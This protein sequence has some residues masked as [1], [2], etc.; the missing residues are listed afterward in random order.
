MKEL[1]TYINEG[2]LGNVDDIMDKT[3]VAVYKDVISNFIM[4]RFSLNSYGNRITSK[5]FE[6]EYDNVKDLF[7]VRLDVNSYARIYINVD[8]NRA[9]IPPKLRSIKLKNPVF[10]KNCPIFAGSTNK[11]DFTLLDYCW[12][13]FPTKSKSW[14]LEINPG[15]DVSIWH[16][17][18]YNINV[19]TSS[20]KYKLLDKKVAL[21]LEAKHGCPTVSF[22]NCTF[23]GT[24]L[25][26]LYFKSI[27]LKNTFLKDLPDFTV[28]PDDVVCTGCDID[29]TSDI[30]F[31]KLY[32][33][34]MWNKFKWKLTDDGTLTWQGIPNDVAWVY[35]RRLNAIGHGE[36]VKYVDPGSPAG[37]V[38]YICYK[39]IKRIKRA[40][41][42]SSYCDDTRI[43]I[44]MPKDVGIKYLRFVPYRPYSERKDV[45]L[46]IFDMEVYT[47]VLDF[48]V[49]VSYYDLKNI[50][51]PNC[52]V[53]YI[54]EPDSDSINKIKQEFLGDFKNED[55]GI[56]LSWYNKKNLPKL[57]MIYIPWQDNYKDKHYGT[58]LVLKKLKGTE[59]KWKI[60]TNYNGEVDSIRMDATKTLD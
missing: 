53:L 56:T 39:D 50:K 7:D 54:D 2:I 10:A 21:L 38:A 48:R 11:M 51:S 37:S 25:N 16:V 42:V 24:K 44:K 6:I 17:D 13:L 60:C 46:N 26:A 59:D 33:K 49:A 3:D 47:E 45:R 29:D 19:N 35:Y 57:N 28:D 8:A 43:K 5:D 30:T 40:K 52:E 15:C 14:K 23:N 18:I 55:T 20:P 12:G 27:D 31:Q 58:F 9:E 22:K 32:I 1:S 34:T 4:D 36:I 41:Y